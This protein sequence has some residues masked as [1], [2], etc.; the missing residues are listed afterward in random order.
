MCIAICKPEGIIIPEEYLTESF[1]YN[2]DGAGFMYAEG[3]ELYIEK[4]FM[5]YQSF[6]DAWE[7]H[8]D[9]VAALHF[10]IRTHGATDQENTHPFQVGNNLGF[11]HNG[12]I[13]QVST[14]DDPSKSDTYHFNQKF[15]QQFYKRDSRFIY[16]D[17]FKDLIKSYIGMSKLVFLNNKGHY[18]IVNEQQGS[19]DNGVWYS[20]NSYKPVAYSRRRN[21][22]T[23]QT[24][25]VP[26]SAPAP[27]TPARTYAVGTKVTIAKDRHNR[28]KSG[29]GTIK[30]FTGGL[31]VGV[32][33]DDSNEVEVIHMSYIDF[34]PDSAFGMNEF[35]IGD[36][37]TRTD[38]AMPDKIGEVMGLVSDS[39]VV[40]WIDANGNPNGPDYL[41]SH[42]K[43]ETY[44]SA[45]ADF[46]FAE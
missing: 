41:I 23:P 19:W 11:I 2:P 33:R 40:K 35:S 27:S 42:W 13:G 36:W 38:G 15:L 14:K 45:L 1:E 16:K 22:C 5:D 32:V 18:T 46:E 26:A 43:L 4:G 25:L 28:W 30:F 12:I 20:N 21:A 37:V 29:T 39:V 6:R 9:K 3:N 24:S 31:M 8:Q 7:P 44:V 34:L 10:R 17:H